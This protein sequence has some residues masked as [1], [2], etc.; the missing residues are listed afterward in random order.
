MPERR[1]TLTALRT[2]AYVA[3]L[4]LL[5]RD[6]FIACFILSSRCGG[7]IIYISALSKFNLKVC[8]TYNVH[9]YT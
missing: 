5:T 7:N 8:N 4:N 1:P 6:H 2:R 9:I 3:F